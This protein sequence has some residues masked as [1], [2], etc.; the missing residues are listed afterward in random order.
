M[1]HVRVSIERA[2]RGAEDPARPL[3]SGGPYGQAWLGVREDNRPRYFARL[4]LRA[5]RNHRLT[6]LAA[7]GVW[8]VARTLF[9]KDRPANGRFRRDPAR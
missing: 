3:H 4:E 6:A 7:T 5:R 1:M 9:F 2:V 8:V